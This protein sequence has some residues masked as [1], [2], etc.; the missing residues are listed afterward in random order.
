MTRNTEKITLL[1]LFFLSFSY[2]FSGLFLIGERSFLSFLLPVVAVLLFSACGFFLLQNAPDCNAKKYGLRDFLSCGTSAPLSTV[3]SV[4]FALFAMVEAG[5]SLFAFCFSV[6][7]FASFLPFWLILIICAGLIV[8]VAA[9]GLTAIGRLSELMAF[10]ILPLLLWIL[11]WK[12]SPIDLTAFSSN[13]YAVFAVTP[14]PI[15]F[16]FSATV[17]KT[18]AMPNEKSLRL[19][20]FASVLGAVL[21]VLCAVL[22]LIY[23]ASEEHIFFLFFGWLTSVIRIALLLCI[24]I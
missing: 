7:A 21:A 4:V 24:R 9:H 6:R 17:S 19:F 10:L 11:L 14:A 1:Q 20:P 15:L 16:L 12:V 2:V 23:G 8:F 18:T 5:L 22:F 3:L 13:L